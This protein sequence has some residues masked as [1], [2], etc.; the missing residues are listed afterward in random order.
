MRTAL[1]DQ[2]LPTEMVLITQDSWQQERS[3]YVAQLKAG[4]T[5]SLNLADIPRVRPTTSQPQ[6]EPT[7]AQTGLVEPAIVAEAKKLFGNDIVQ[8]ID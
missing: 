2:Q 5:Q 3:D 8:V 4:T 7:T 6:N 1:A